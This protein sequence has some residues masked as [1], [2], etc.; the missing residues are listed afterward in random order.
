M[1]TIKNIPDSYTINVP[2]MTVNGNLLITGNSTNI[3]STNLTVT[4][5]I[6]TLN[7]NVTGTPTLNAAI[8]VNRGTSANV[9]IRWNESVDAWQITNDGSTFGNILTAGAPS[10]NVNIT[11]VT[12]Y[13]T[14]N[15]VTFYTGAVSSG[16]SGI[17]VDNTSG[18]QQ[19]LTTKGAAIAYS[20]IFG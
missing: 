5:N 9:E 19:E 11:G 18:S 8:E 7:G 12:L 20:I 6:I 10:G 14:A 1:A 3:Y 16:K 2:L 13:D 17:Y 15:V 4:D